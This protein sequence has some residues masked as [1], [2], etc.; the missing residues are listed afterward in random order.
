[1]ATRVWY[2]TGTGNS[3]YAA[4]R[5][6]KRLGVEAEDLFEWIRDG[7]HEIAES[8]TA[9]RIVLVTPTYAWRVPTIVTDWMRQVP[10]KK[11][12]EVS[13]VLT[14][15]GSIG[16][17]GR[18]A[19][20]IAHECGLVYRGAAGIIMPE[21][22]LAMFSVPDQAKSEAIIDRA[23]PV[24]DAIAEKLLAGKALSGKSGQTAEDVVEHFGLFAA[25]ESGPVNTMFYKCAVKDKDF[26]VSDSCIGCGLCAKGCVLNNITLSDGKPVWNGNCTQC[27]A[28]ICNCPKEA[29]EYGTKSVG[30]PRYKCTKEV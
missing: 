28:C 2:Y 21:N 11:G 29:I 3:R 16:A 26:T 14:C 18:Y 13:F 15:G 19:K 9:D 22:Y 17:A 4:K 8:V 25:I 10:F 7:K 12:T 27:M 20:K 6:A 23:E 24:I 5:I 1:M 30:Q